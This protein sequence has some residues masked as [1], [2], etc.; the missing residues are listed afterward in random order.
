MNIAF[1]WAMFASF[2]CATLALPVVAYGYT[3]LAV[4]FGAV[5]IIGLLV[6]VVVMLF[7]RQ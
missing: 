4:A 7:G 1:F 5:A 2:L 6:A 3:C